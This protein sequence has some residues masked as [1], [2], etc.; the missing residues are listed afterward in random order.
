MAYKFP[1]RPAV[2]AAVS[3]AALVVPI[4]AAAQ[5]VSPREEIVVIGAIKDPAS[6]EYASDAA[7]E[8]VPELPVVYAEPQS[9]SA[10]DASVDGSAPAA[11]E[12]NQAVEAQ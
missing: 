12:L 7:D 10:D 3:A 1:I 11:A 2:A 4:V 8:A 9:A 6:V 5:Q